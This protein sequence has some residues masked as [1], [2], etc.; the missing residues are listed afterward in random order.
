MVI[1]GIIQFFHYMNAH[2]SELP[3]F[4]NFPPQQ[5]LPFPQNFES[6]SETKSSIFNPIKVEANTQQSH[7]SPV[8]SKES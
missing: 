3:F 4:Y 7:E 5:F 2:Y 8:P 1:D 6:A